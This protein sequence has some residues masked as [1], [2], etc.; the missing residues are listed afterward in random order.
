MDHAFNAS[1]EKGR[2]ERAISTV[3]RVTSG[4]I[5]HAYKS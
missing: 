5:N 3:N 4:T 1:E 2:F